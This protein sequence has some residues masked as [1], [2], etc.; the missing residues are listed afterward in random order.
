M[1]LR[2]MP[3]I[4]AGGMTPSSVMYPVI[5]AGPTIARSGQQKSVAARISSGQAAARYRARSRPSSF[6]RRPSIPRML[7]LIIAVGT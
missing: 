2:L 6:L 4:A 3:N 1:Y 7:T 5:S